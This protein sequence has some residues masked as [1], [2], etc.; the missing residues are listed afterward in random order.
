MT[1]PFCFFLS[2]FVFSDEEVF[3][4]LVSEMIRND[5]AMRAVVTHAE[6]LVFTSTKLPLRLWSESKCF[7][8]PFSFPRYVCYWI[9]PGPCS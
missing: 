8:L 9:D 4:N 3:K 2:G 6:L 1:Q 5:L 7:V